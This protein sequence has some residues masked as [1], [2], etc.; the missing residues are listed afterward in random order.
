MN[1]FDRIARF[2]APLSHAAPEAAG[3]LDDAAF[4]KPAA[5]ETWVITTDAMSEGVHYLAD[6]PPELI[7]RKL[8]RTNV[9]DLAAKGATPRFYTLNIMLPAHIDDA[10]IQRFTA[11]LAVDQRLFD[12]QLIG[13]DSIAVKGVHASFA[14]TAFGVVSENQQLLKRSGAQIGDIVCVSGRLGEAALGLKCA[15]GEEVQG[16]TAQQREYVISRYELPEPRIHL[17][18]ALLGL[19][20]SCM[21]ISDGLVQDGGHIAKASNV[22]LILEMPKIP[23][24]EHLSVKEAITHGDDY[25]LLFTVSEA[26]MPALFQKARTFDVAITAIGKVETGEGVRVLDIDGKEVDFEKSGWQH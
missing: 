25:E 11:G 10:W 9:S 16:L 13:G 14:I 5:G 2:F 4:I 6:T 21:D 3:L 12:M 26:D 8:L 15:S 22:K 7:A 20:S 18:Q 1:E 19:A 23:T 24:V 17:G